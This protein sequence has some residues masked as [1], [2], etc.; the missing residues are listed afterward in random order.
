MSETLNQLKQAREEAKL[1]ATTG[2]GGNP[3]G[4]L[5]ELPPGSEIVASNE[6]TIDDPESKESEEINPETQVA[7]PQGKLIKI[8]DQEFTSEE[9]AIAYA[10]TLEQ[11]KTNAELYNQGVRDA[12]A[13]GKIPAEQIAPPEEDNFEEKFY[14]NPKEALKQIQTKARDEA[15]EAIRAENRKEALWN[16]FLAENPDIRRKDAERVLQENWNT[17]GQMT[18]TSKAMKLLAQRTR[19]EYAEILES[20]KPRTELANKS[21]QLAGSGGNQQKS[22][23]QQKKDDRPLDFVSQL[24]AA[25][26]R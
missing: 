16:Q 12:L 3:D 5:E 26:K 24:R 20:F 21:G 18:D 2:E 19:A 13:A 10:Q 17:I 6:E 22:V 8:G 11:E 14:A 23:T 7:K 1:A 4:Q 25:S 9:D 15:L